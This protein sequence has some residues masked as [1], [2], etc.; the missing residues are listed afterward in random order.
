MHYLQTLREAL[1]AVTY[2]STECVTAEH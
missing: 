2:Y 1:Y